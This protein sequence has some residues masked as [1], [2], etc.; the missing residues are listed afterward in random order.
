MGMA[1]LRFLVDDRERGIIE[2]L[3]REDHARTWWESTRLNIGDYALVFADGSDYAGSETKTIMIIE[4]KTYE[5]F[6]ASIK[7][8]RI[9]NLKDL[10]AIRETH[11]SIHLAILIEGA[12]PKSPVA[13][14]SCK[15]I[16]AKINHMRLRDRFHI[17]ESQNADDTVDVLR[18]L[19][20]DTA[21]LFARSRPKVLSAPCDERGTCGASVARAPRPQRRINDDVIAMYEQLPG[22]GPKTSARLVAQHVPFAEYIA[23]NAAYAQQSREDGALDSRILCAIMGVSARG[24]LA[25]RALVPS[26]TLIELCDL[27]KEDLAQ[28]KIAGKN[29][30]ILGKRVFDCLHTSL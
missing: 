30:R 10:V 4:R 23:K 12:R 20:E 9:E 25:I 17:F 19:V 2:I 11:Q 14:I 16:R 5:D 26:G 18:G 1:S 24:A 13:G 3:D 7:D 21:T 15:A 6:A 29:Q 8:G 22:V 27:S 28:L